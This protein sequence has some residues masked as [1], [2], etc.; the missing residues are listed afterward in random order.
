MRAWSPCPVEEETEKQNT[1][2]V[3]DQ[4]LCAPH[5]ACLKIPVLFYIYTNHHKLAS[6]PLYGQHEIAMILAQQR[7]V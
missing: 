5:T 1:Y 6:P 4:V 3:V 2:F 7:P